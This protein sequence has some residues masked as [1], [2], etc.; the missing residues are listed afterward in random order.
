MDGKFTDVYISSIPKE[1][2]IKPLASLVRNEEI[3]KASNERLKK[4][5]Y[6]VWR[7]LEYAISNS[8]GLNAENIKFEK[9]DSGRW[10]T[11]EFEFSL[12]HTDGAV[13]V[14]ISSE[15]VGID[16]E[17][18]KKP[19]SRSFAERILTASELIK[20]ESVTPAEREEYLI[21]KWTSKEAYFKSLHLSE[22]LPSMEVGAD[23]KIQT[24]SV[25]FNGNRYIYSVATKIPIRVFG[26][27]N[28]L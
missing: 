13:A 20:Y 19:R 22:F 16:I 4:E 25:V 21:G 17:L 26:D 23:S 11:A 5:K 15:P 10:R 6:F 12:S 1:L 3:S 9:L 28:L 14:A 8:L 18:V 2:V 27:I 7:L 24:K